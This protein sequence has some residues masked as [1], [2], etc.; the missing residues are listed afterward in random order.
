[1]SAAGGVNLFRFVQKIRDAVPPRT[2]SFAGLHG[3][4]AFLGVDALGRGPGVAAADC[5]R[6]SLL[7]SARN[8]NS[9]HHFALQ[10]FP[11]GSGPIECPPQTTA[12]MPVLDVGT[13]HL[14]APK[15]PGGG[16]ASASEPATAV[17]VS[18]TA[19][20]DKSGQ[21]LAGD[22]F[23]AACTRESDFYKAVAASVT[24]LNEKGYI[25]MLVGDTHNMTLAA[26][27][28]LRAVG[29]DNVCVVHFS[30]DTRMGTPDAPLKRALERKL[31]KGVVN[32]GARTVTT[33]S[34]KMRKEYE[35]RYVDSYG[36]HDRGV[37]TLK[38]MRNSFPI[39]LSVDVGVLEPALA[40][41]VPQ[42][43]AGGLS[44]R[45]LLHLVSVLRG[46][47]II[48]MDLHG[49]DPD[50]D[51]YR[52]CGGEGVTSI[53]CGRVAKEML[54]KAYTCHPKTRVQMEEHLKQEQVQ[55][56]EL[57][58]YPEH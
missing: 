48:G 21:D 17:V 29:H 26:L 18:P 1:M 39:Y 35:V 45:E 53:V 14:D 40:P 31:V 23:D 56:K 47:N 25:P 11:E 49:Y 16:V 32:F 36:L 33:P 7:Q 22:R 13:L 41:G 34:R 19:A 10:W 51:V 54:C 30:A 42:P 12:R 58:Q 8:G 6:R 28:G 20:Q 44:V 4:V 52:R 55:G 2:P 3:P 15:P 46:P 27:D 24:G 38:D 5:M 9:D 43:E 37:F 57:P 50:C